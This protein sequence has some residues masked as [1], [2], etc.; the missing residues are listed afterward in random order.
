MQFCCQ[1]LLRIEADFTVAFH[2]SLGELAPN[3]P[4]VNG[5]GGRELSGALAHC[6]LWAALTRDDSASVERTVRDFAAEHRRRGFPDDAYAFLSHALLRSI[7][8]VMSADWSSELS[9]GLVSYAL[10]LQPC[11][12]QGARGAD[13][14][15]AARPSGNGE[16][17]LELLL[18][19]LRSRHFTG[20]ERAL[21][22]VC[23]RIMLRT[24]V[25]LRA[26]R[27]EQRQDPVVI[28]AVM[29]NLMLMGY[30]PG[31]AL[32]SAATARAEAAQNGMRA[33]AA[34][35]ATPAT[36]V[37]TRV[38]QPDHGYERAPDRRAWWS[39]RRRRD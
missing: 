14:A 18:D 26:P 9:S 13:G 12:Q 33:I 39:L 32:T 35:T 34:R 36:G 29:K 22:A 30:A 38:P 10:W 7:R 20:E 28:A 25:D 17:S 24:G 5:P 1:R 8:T 3:L 15:R 31:P 21:D 23:T 4:S 16:I 2:R 19:D 6:L 11:L 27:P 37:Q